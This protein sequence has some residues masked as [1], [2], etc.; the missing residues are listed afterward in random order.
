MNDN[1]NGVFSLPRMNGS[2]NGCGVVIDTYQVFDSC[3]D[4][5]CFENVK[6]F[7]DSMG[8]SII[9]HTTQIRAKCAESWYNDSNDTKDAHMCTSDG[10]CRP[11]RM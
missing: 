3:R 11:C 1:R 10:R 7:L 4:R 5:D 2:T 9:E 8:Q 6:V